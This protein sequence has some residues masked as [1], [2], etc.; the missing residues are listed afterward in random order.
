MPPSGHWLTAIIGM[1]LSWAARRA[2]PR[3]GSSGRVPAPK[4][5]ST[6]PSQAAS[7]AAK[8]R[9]DAPGAMVRMAISAGT[10]GRAASRG[11]GFLGGRAGAS[12]ANAFGALLC[13]LRKRAPCSLWPP[14]CSQI[15]AGAVWA[16]LMASVRFRLASLPGWPRGIID[17]VKIT[18]RSSPCRAKHSAAPVK[19]MVSVPWVTMK[20]S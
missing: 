13:V 18:G 7:A 6:A 11:V 17:P 14:N 4:T 1:P 5:R 10:K 2:A 8:A 9:E 12:A 16:A 3:A 20:P 19:A 15:P